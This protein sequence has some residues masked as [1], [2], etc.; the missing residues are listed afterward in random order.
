MSGFQRPLVHASATSHDSQDATSGIDSP[1]PLS[2]YTC[3]LRVTTCH[4][5]ST[6]DYKRRHVD[7]PKLTHAQNIPTTFTTCIFVNETHHTKN[8]SL[9]TT[10]DAYRSL[11]S[12]DLVLSAHLISTQ[13]AIFVESI[14]SQPQLQINLFIHSNTSYKTHLSR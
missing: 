10:D 5:V 3:H 14:S 9:L 13:N 4:N 12:F 2:L 8:D 11:Q 6:S 7:Q 1:R